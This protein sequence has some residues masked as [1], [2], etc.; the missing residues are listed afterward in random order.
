MSV[1][2]VLGRLG[3]SLVNTGS[4]RCTFTGGRG[5]FTAG[6]GRVSFPKGREES[7]ANVRLALPGLPGHS[8]SEGSL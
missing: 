3:C 8:A 5:R 2:P 6:L 4:Q 1:G 7:R